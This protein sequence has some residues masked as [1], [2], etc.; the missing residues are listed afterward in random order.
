MN[1]ANTEA[2]WESS[3]K[4]V[5]TVLDQILAD[6][7]DVDGQKVWTYDGSKQSIAVYLTERRVDML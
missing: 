6:V 2:H 5:D 3:E 7:Q 1:R 4:D